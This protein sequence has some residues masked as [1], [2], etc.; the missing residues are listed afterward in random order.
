MS[1][2]YMKEKYAKANCSSGTYNIN[3]EKHKE[4]L[5]IAI[6]CWTGPYDGDPL[7]LVIWVGQE[8]GHGSVE[9]KPQKKTRENR[10]DTYQQ[11]AVVSKTTRSLRL[12]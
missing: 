10:L 3:K 1:T 8:G 5:L 12:D 4:L 6:T 9:V 11:Q 7:P 2:A